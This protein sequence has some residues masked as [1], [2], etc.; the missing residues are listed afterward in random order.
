MSI[1]PYAA[2]PPVS[3]TN[4]SS[5]SEAQ[6]R[7]VAQQFE[8]IFLRQ[9]LEPLQSA[10]SSASGGHVY[11]SLV[12]GSAADAAAAGGGIGLA[13][14]LARALMQAAGSQQAIDSSGLEPPPRDDGPAPL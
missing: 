14:V 3:A 2:L 5:P 6:I 1:A 7:E 4:G 8:A 9:L 10:T 13:E 11:G 12:V